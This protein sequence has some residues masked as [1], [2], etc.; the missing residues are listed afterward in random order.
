MAAVAIDTPNCMAMFC[1]STG[2]FC[3]I[4]AAVCGSACACCWATTGDAGPPPY[5]KSAAEGTPLN[6]ALGAIS[7]F[8][9]AGA[10]PG[11]LGVPARCA[12]Q[13]LDQGEVRP[14]PA[15]DPAPAN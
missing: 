8:G 5:A 4:A 2:N 3:A 1:T 7:P 15:H 9:A 14:G 13:R 6:G 10:A 12:L 11:A